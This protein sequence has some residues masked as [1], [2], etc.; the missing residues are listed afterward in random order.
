MYLSVPF[1][2]AA[3]ASPPQSSATH[4]NIHKLGEQ[5]EKEELK[6]E[7]DS[8]A[9]AGATAAAPP[10]ARRLGRKVSNVPPS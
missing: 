10:L 1:A 7:E 2:A 4:L 6:I 9:A 3:A 5:V 8:A